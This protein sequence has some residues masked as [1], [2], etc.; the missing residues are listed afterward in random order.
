MIKNMTSQYSYLIEQ[1]ISKG[2]KDD[3]SIPC[4]YDV[5]FTHD[6]A[7]LSYPWLIPVY[8][9][10]L[11]ADFEEPAGSGNWKTYSRYYWTRH[12]AL[13]SHDPE[14]LVEEHVKW[15]VDPA[16]KKIN[17]KFWF[18][19][20]DGNVYSMAPTRHFYELERDYFK[21]NH[22]CSKHPEEFQKPFDEEN[23][24]GPNYLYKK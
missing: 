5:A 16:T 2:K 23:A 11:W 17:L 4:I 3:I 10:L 13:V 12:A 15:Y 19:T 24:P 7:G 21:R 20:M 1:A 14:N 6:Q 8:G 9:K 22:L 18:E